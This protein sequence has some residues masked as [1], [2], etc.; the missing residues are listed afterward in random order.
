EG[1]NGEKKGPFP[2]ALV[3][4]WYERS[5]LLPSVELS[6]D[7]GKQWS[8]IVTL[9]RRNGPAFPISSFSKDPKGMGNIAIAT[10]V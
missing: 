5:Q 4:T 10:E 1:S 9:R 3:S 8:S 2:L 7:D 6:A